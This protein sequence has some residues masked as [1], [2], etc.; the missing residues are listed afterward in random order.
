MKF[1]ITVFPFVTS[2]T[3]GLTVNDALYMHEQAT[4]VK[5]RYVQWDEQ[6]ENGAFSNNSVKGVLVK[7]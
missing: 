1:E 3:Y 6:C 7:V 2:I 4:G 5:T